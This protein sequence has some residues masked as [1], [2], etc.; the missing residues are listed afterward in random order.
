MLPPKKHFESSAS[1][2]DSDSDIDSNAENSDKS[3][4]S[5][6]IDKSD[7]SSAL[8]HTRD[9]SDLRI[10]QPFTWMWISITLKNVGW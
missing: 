3:D 1:N 9:L 7:K 5:H 10:P 6:R 2:S 8:E 4:K